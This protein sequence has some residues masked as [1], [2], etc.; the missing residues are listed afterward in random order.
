MLQ[1]NLIYNGNIESVNEFF[2]VYEMSFY[3]SHFEQSF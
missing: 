3:P 1:K 2:Y